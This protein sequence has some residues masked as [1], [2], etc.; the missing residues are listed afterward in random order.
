VYSLSDFVS[1]PE[2]ASELVIAGYTE[3]ILCKASTH[4]ATVRLSKKGYKRKKKLFREPM[5]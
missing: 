4:H 2:A 1:V 3:A 5:V